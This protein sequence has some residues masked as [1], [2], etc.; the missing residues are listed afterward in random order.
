MGSRASAM[1][2]RRGVPSPRGGNCCCCCSSMGAGAS[3]PAAAAL[4]QAH[5]PE[6]RGRT[7]VKRITGPTVLSKQQPEKQP[8]RSAGGDTPGAVACVRSPHRRR[9]A[10]GEARSADLCR[11]CAPRPS[12]PP[13]VGLSAE[14][15]RVQCTRSVDVQWPHSIPKSQWPAQRRKRCVRQVRAGRRLL[16][17]ILNASTRSHGSHEKRD[18]TKMQHCCPPLQSQ[19]SEDEWMT[20]LSA[21]A[22]ARLFRGWSGRIRD[23]ARRSESGRSDHSASLY[24]ERKSR[25]IARFASAPRAARRGLA[26]TGFAASQG[27]HK[28]ARPPP[29][30]DADSRKGAAH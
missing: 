8:A 27:E 3:A 6:G 19:K 4:R 5:S 18:G 13:G 14:G 15:R 28:A 12:S 17:A 29:A 25:G 11:T 21:F 2:L 23:S 26:V 30:A 7:A 9:R 24:P 22:A 20:R 1:E 16:S 10:A